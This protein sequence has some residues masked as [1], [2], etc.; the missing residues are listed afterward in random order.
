MA[1]YDGKQGKADGSLPGREVPMGQ[2][3]G[4]FDGFG[5]HDGQFP[6]KVEPHIY[7]SPRTHHK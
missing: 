1:Q 3:D 6:H 7:H 5:E 2:H 4:K